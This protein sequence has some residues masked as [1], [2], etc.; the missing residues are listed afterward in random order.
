[1]TQ[2]S[3]DCD[4]DTEEEATNSALQVGQGVIPGEEKMS[5]NEPSFL[6][7]N[8]IKAGIFLTKSEEGRHILQK[9]FKQKAGSDARNRGCEGRGISKCDALG[10]EE[11]TKRDRT[12]GRGC[13]EQQEPGRLERQAGPVGPNRRA[14]HERSPVTIC[15]LDRKINKW[16]NGR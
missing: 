8:E 11:G 5:Q 1:M 2:Y 13:L 16:I 3:Q 9:E 14:G 7:L 4:E 12:G 15:V 6:S 10:G